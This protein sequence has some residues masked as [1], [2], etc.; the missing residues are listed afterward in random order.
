M[1]DMTEESSNITP[2]DVLAADTTGFGCIEDPLASL[3][4]LEESEA[5]IDIC[6]SCLQRHK[7]FCYLQE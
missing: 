7:G 1:T 2:S 4:P 6:H 5:N 3:P